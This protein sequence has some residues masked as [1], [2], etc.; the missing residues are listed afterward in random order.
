MSLPQFNFL[1]KPSKRKSSPCSLFQILYFFHCFKQ[2]VYNIPDCKQLLSLAF[3]FPH[4]L[5]QFLPFPPGKKVWLCMCTPSPP[6]GVLA[7]ED[8]VKLSYG[9]S[10]AVPDS[11]IASH[12]SEPETR[13]IRSSICLISARQPATPCGESIVGFIPLCTP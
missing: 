2:S 5:S 13:S 6:P 8:T 7:D 10:Y 1:L 12:L 4:L 3:L 9:L 11:S